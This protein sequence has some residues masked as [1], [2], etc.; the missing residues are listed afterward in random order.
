M[1]NEYSAEET[2]EA[3]RVLEQNPPHGS[4]HAIGGRQFVVVERGGEKKLLRCQ[5][6]WFCRCDYCM[7]PDA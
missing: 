3:C 2:A 4:K 1:D 6:P 5:A 7:Y